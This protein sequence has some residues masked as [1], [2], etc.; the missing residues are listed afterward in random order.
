MINRGGPTFDRILTHIDDLPVIDCH[1]HMLGPEHL[2]RFSEPIAALIAGY[3]ANDLISAG[4]KEQEL[5]FLKDE[6]VATGD[7]W[8]LF[9]VY[10]ERSQHTAYARVAKLVM[11]D[12]YGEQVM[13]LAALNRIGERLAER[14]PGYLSS[15]DD[16]CQYTLCHNG[17]AR[18]AAG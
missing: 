11:R 2:V 12:A 6:T 10:W 17:R 4:M 5:A 8:P 18:L 15:D 14:D 13:S 7:K 16:E 9:R 1:E 3:F